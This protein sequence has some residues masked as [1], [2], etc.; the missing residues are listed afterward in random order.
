MLS[1]PFRVA[2]RTAEAVIRLWSQRL[3]LRDGM[4]IMHWLWQMGIIIPT[5]ST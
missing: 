1:M 3:A 2:G 4:H 5:T